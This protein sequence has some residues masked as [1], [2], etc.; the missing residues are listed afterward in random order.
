VKALGGDD[1]VEPGKGRDRVHGGDGQDQ[2][3]ARDSHRDRI[4][5]GRGEDVVFADPED[6]TEDCERVREPKGV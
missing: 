1:C 2:I 6:R 5:C 4:L 3:D